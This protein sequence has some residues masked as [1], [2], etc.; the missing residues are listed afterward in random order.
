M[1]KNIAYKNCITVIIHLL[2]IASVMETYN[3]HVPSLI[4]AHCLCA[5]YW[6][7]FHL[8]IPYH[9]TTTLLHYFSD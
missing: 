6:P 5:A 3:D 8:V 7:I 2:S 9:Y 1:V 4:W